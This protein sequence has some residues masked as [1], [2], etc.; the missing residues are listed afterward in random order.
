MPDV[1]PAELAELRPG[2]PA[3]PPPSAIATGAR[4]CAANGCGPSRPANAGGSTPR[5]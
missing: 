1:D 5:T 4:R 2:P 3:R